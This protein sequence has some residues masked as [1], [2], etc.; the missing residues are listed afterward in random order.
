MAGFEGG[1]RIYLNTIDPWRVHNRVTS[2][3]AELRD[4]GA[5]SPLRVGAECSVDPSL[6]GG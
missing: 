3:L 1:S 6:L 5:I 2:T 4:A